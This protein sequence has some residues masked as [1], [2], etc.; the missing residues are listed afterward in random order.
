MSNLQTY[1]PT[2]HIDLDPTKLKARQFSRSSGG[3][4]N[5]KS[6]NSLWTET[7]AER[8]QRLA[9]EVS[10]KKRR[11][12]DAP[13]DDETTTG[14]NKR[15]KQDEERIK[16]NVDEYTVRPLS[17][18]FFALIFFLNPPSFSKNVE[19]QLLS[20]NMRLR[21]ILKRKI[22]V[23]GIMPEIWVSEEGSWM[24]IKEIKC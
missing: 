12:T 1:F 11:I 21:R 2:K 20:I 4:V 10:G 13:V 5:N 19:V 17:S 23:F 16:K 14:A 6:D 9:D 24:M 18:L 3:P 8:Q 7:P 15:R 22:W